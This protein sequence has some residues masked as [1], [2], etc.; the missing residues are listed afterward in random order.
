[1]LYFAYGSNLSSARLRERI[2]SA[3]LVATGRLPEHKLLFHKIGR[4]GT[5]KCNACFTGRSSDHLYGAVYRI[6]PDHKIR[7]DRA[8]GMGK[9][10]EIKNV[11]ITASAT[12]KIEAFTYFA[13]RTA[14]NIRPFSWYR[15]HVFRGACEHCFPRNYIEQ[16]AAVEA[17]EDPEPA[18]AERELA[19]YAEEASSSLRQ[20]G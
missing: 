13:T 14:R 6:D 5:A 19:I 10:Y 17:K 7:L 9:G 4:D 18:R 20:T 16:I 3:E 12:E 11:T 8:E 2:P 15:E 1:M